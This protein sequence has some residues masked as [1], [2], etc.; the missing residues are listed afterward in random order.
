M[1]PSQLFLA[2][3]GSG[4]ALYIGLADDCYIVASEPYG[5]VEETSQYVRIDGETRGRADRQFVSTAPTLENSPVSCVSPTTAP[6]CP[7]DIR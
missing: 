5:V 3:R 2:L 1:R 6:S 7:V 4:Q